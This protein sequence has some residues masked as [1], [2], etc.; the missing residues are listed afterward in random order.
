MQPSFPLC[1]LP[2]KLPKRGPGWDA[3]RAV[4]IAR[5]IHQP[6]LSQK[7]AC[8]QSG[9]PDPAVP[10]WLVTIGCLGKPGKPHAAGRA[11]QRCQ[12][13]SAG[14]SPTFYS[15][16]QHSPA[17]RCMLGCFLISICKS[18]SITQ[19]SLSVLKSLA[20][21]LPPDPNCQ[22]SLTHPKPCPMK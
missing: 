20:V 6:A 3:S 2:A 13:S 18:T 10:R 4:W 21:A 15:N 1:C 7:Q 22:P 14:C 16:T 12:V 9:Q 19:M 8:P 5:I 17:L 11:L